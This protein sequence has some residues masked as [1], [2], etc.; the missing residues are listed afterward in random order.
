MMAEKTLK[1]SKSRTGVVV[2]DKMHKTAVVSVQ[3]R[4]PHPVFKKIITTSKRYYVHDENNQLNIGDRVRIVET[5]PLSKLKRWR[6]GE[7]L[8]KAQE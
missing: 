1:K 8:E 7:L 4:S 2:S 3:R 5:R 6:L